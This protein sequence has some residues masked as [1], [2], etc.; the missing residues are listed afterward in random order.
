MT[1]TLLNSW[2]QMHWRGLTR[3]LLLLVLLGQSALLLHESG[4]STAMADS[5][6]QL[7][8]H[9]QPL[10]GITDPAPQPLRQSRVIRLRVSPGQH[11]VATSPVNIPHARGPPRA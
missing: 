4:H 9:A 11:W 5:E 8:L 1:M 3:V 10:P 7:C 6:C 2:R